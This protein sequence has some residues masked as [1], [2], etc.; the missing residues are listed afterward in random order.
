MQTENLDLLA[1]KLVEL[2]VCTP[3]MVFNFPVRDLLLASHRKHFFKFQVK[4][5]T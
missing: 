3:R 4:E 2:P 5:N 1:I